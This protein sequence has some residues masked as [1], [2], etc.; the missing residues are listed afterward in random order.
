[1]HILKLIARAVSLVIPLLTPLAMA[2]PPADAG[3][4]WLNACSYYQNT[5]PAFQ[6]QSTAG[7]L[8][9]SNGCTTNNVTGK[10][11]EIDQLI[12]DV[13]PNY[14]AWWYTTTPSPA[15]QIIHAYTP[16]GEVLGDCRLDVAGGD[17][18][19][20]EY[21]WGAS[22]A[23]IAGSKAIGGS[24]TTGGCTSLTTINQSIT[25]SQTF[26]WRVICRNGT[27]PRT[28]EGFSACAASSSRRK[29]TAAQAWP[30][31]VQA[32]SG[33]RAIAGSEAGDGR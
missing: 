19:A 17:G 12:D 3:V 6:W 31:S 21:F 18:F 9:A 11:L 27:G 23:Q 16:A 30:H 33:T 26:G 29:R 14:G 28:P 24:G 5:A 13:T 8:R 32:T 1:M 2:A 7:K 4:L 25:P 10:S 22:P 20:A 15:I